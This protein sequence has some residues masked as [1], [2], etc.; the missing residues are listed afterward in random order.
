MRDEH[1]LTVKQRTFAELVAAGSSQIAAVY[2]AGYKPKSRRNG[3]V[4][5][6]RMASHPNIRALILQSLDEA[7]VGPDKVSHVFRE[8]FAAKRDDQIPLLRL[9][10]DMAKEY[11]RIVG[12]YAPTQHQALTARLDLTREDPRVLAW[13][14]REKRRPTEEERASIL[15][16]K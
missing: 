7:H 8:G 9:K 6:T 13:M 4:L 14:A 11:N 10:L 15:E 12:A 16:Q 1:G 5:G 3:N 2:K